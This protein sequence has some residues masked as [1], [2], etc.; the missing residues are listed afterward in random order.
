MDLPP[1]VLIGAGAVVAALIS[2]AVSFISLINSKEQ[3]TSE[4]RQDWINALRDDLSDFLAQTESI[5]NTLSIL[6]TLHKNEQRYGEQINDNVKRFID[7]C[8]EQNKLF[9][10]ICLRLNP[11]EHDKLIERLDKVKDITQPISGNTT[12]A[13]LDNQ[14]RSI[15]DQIKEQTKDI[16]A[17]SQVMLKR[18]WKRVKRG[19]P[20]HYITKYSAIVMFI[21]TLGLIICLS[22]G[23]VKMPGITFQH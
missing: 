14:T 20:I 19:E 3:K 7:V 22:F 11:K 21:V 2:S 12:A 1:T 4:F 18:E 16:I 6:I 10:R 8:G 9:S 17:D 5:N 15:T 13:D 23:L